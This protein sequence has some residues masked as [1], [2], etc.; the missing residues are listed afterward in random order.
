MKPI[1]KRAA[2]YNEPKGMRTVLSEE[3]V[4]ATMAVIMSGAPFASAKKVI[5]AMA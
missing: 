2:P 5:P 4:P 1:L 3:L